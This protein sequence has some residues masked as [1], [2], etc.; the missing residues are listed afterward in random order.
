MF[1]KIEWKK[2][3]QGGGRRFWPSNSL[4]SVRHW[5]YGIKTNGFIAFSFELV[6]PR[7][8]M[9]LEY[10]AGFS[11]RIKPTRT[12]AYVYTGYMHAYIYIYPIFQGGGQSPWRK[13]GLRIIAYP[14]ARGSRPVWTWNRTARTSCCW[15]ARR[16]TTPDSA[17]ARRAPNNT[18]GDPTRLKHKSAT[19][20]VTRGAQDAFSPEKKSPKINNLIM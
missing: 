5:A 18:P 16:D 11:S 9:F 8:C 14:G 17:W 10:R 15:R 1:K 19:G 6:Y 2:T 7:I 3:F 12:L 13:Y 20:R 4:P